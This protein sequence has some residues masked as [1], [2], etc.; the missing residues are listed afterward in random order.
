MNHVYRSKPDA[1]EDLFG[2]GR[3][4]VGVVHLPALPGSPGYH[5]SAIDALVD[6][7]L[8]DARRYA[9]GGVHGLIVEN[10]GDIPFAKPDDLGPETA[11]VMAVIVRPRPPRG[12]LPLGIN[13]LANGARHALAIAQAAGR[14][15]CGS[16]SGRTPTSRTRASSR[17]RRRR[18][19]ATG[20]GCAP[21]GSGCSP[22]STSSTAPT[23]SRP[24]E[25]GRADARPRVLRRGRGD[26]HR[27]ADRRRRRPRRAGGRARGDAPAAA[28]GQRRH[29]GDVAARSWGSRT[30]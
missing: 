1:L 17:G 2:R 20:R 16:T 8:E 24:T 13:V 14:A 11:A 18:R 25:A 10:H 29:A 23:R 5:G 12:G 9:R 15:S 6:A 22:T 3:V 7:A 27:P 4:V 21:R 28:G 19:P 30:A 26:R